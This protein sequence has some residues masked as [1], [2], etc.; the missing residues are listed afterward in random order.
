M[1]KVSGTVEVMTRDFCYLRAKGFDEYI[2]VPLDE[3]RRR[4][5][6]VG[7][8]ISAIVNPTGSIIGGPVAV[9][10]FYS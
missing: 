5:L 8:N 10:V 6:N 4:L 3:E 7:S 2:F 1:N 9:A